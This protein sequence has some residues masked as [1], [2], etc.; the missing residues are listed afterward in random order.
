MD[1]EIL[2]PFVTVEGISPDALD[3]IPSAPSSPCNDIYQPL[4]DVVNKELHNI[5]DVNNIFVPGI[6]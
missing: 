5:L 2:E 3:T 4:M 6:F 1:F